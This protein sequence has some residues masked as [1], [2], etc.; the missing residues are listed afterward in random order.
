MTGDR[1]GQEAAPR[2][3]AL[4]RV[5][6][7]LTLLAVSVAGTILS[8]APA[9]TAEAPK[10]YTIAIHVSHDKES[11]CTGP[12]EVDAI[13]D[14][15]PRRVALLNKAGGIRGQPIRFVFFDDCEKVAQTKANVT[16]ALSGENV[17][18]MIG[19]WDSSRGAEVINDIGKSG[20]P[21]ISELSVETL[22]SAYPNVYTLT[23]S[24]RHEQLVFQ[25]FVEEEP[26]R[27]IAFFGLEDDLYTKA[28]FDYIAA[29][30]LGPS[31]VS[32]EW[33]KR[34]G[35]TPS[36]RFESVVNEIKRA[37]PDLLFLSIGSDRGAAFLRR[38]ADQGIKIPVFLGRG[39]ARDMQTAYGGVE[40]YEGDIYELAEGGIANLLN[41]RLEH[42]KR[43]PLFRQVARKYN[44][45]SKPLGYGVRYGDLVALVAEAAAEGVKPDDVAGLSVPAVRERIAKALARLAEG[46][47]VWR[48]WAQDWS[49][50]PERASSERSLL[51]WRPP[52]QTTTI[53]APNQY[54]QT[55]SGLAKVPVF[56]V[57]LDMLRIYRVDTS[58]KS[59]EADFFFTL[60]SD[61]GIP[62]DSIGFTNAY[63]GAGTN[64]RLVNIQ[65]I[66]KEPA[67]AMLPT[68][69]IFK[70]SGKFVFE[71]DLRKFPFDEQVFSISFQPESTSSPFLLQ[72]P[73]EQLLG[74]K[75]SVDGWTIQDR[76]VGSNDLIIRSVAGKMS[77]ERIIPYYN[78]NYTW[79]MKRQ[80]VDYI[81]R[82][83]VPLAF[84]LIVA[85]LA[86]FIPRQDFH[87]TIAIQVT[88]LLSAIALYLALNQPSADD[89]TL[90]DQIFVVAYAS[91]STMIALSIFEVNP[92]LA[93]SRTIRWS[94]YFVQ[95]YLLPLVVLGILSYV[96]FLAA[97]DFSLVEAIARKWRALMTWASQRP[98]S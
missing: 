10:E 21:L 25:Q 14:L 72:P 55:G 92:V 97:S 23:R 50:T 76:Y 61:S 5:I 44:N 74:Y 35:E 96:I 42:L 67:G 18:A 32:K 88:A 94:V 98:I 43:Q 45:E 71:P 91:I 34:E 40:A 9:R 80:I 12:V 93:G 86:N 15:V 87:A 70:V 47:K 52:G 79:V 64:S 48:G 4:H 6:G 36:E 24:V 17:I 75:F 63:R 82:V 31:L 84:I 29:S 39:S 65:Q 59:F 95:I 7:A 85:Y 73:S 37:R 69:R 38:L 1:N 78:F 89:A 16:E 51:V 8:G 2:R 13:K 20:I 66:H 46:R 33:I 30:S 27:R 81:L 83:L 60:R 41:E 26:F 19:L 58:D 11:S 22:F 62:E 53:L 56:S 54:V 49:F 57:H 90:S 68:T 28:Y 77:E 3:P